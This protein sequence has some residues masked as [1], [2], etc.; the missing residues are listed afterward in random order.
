MLCVC[1]CVCVCVC[2]QLCPNLCDPMDGSL[3]GSSVHG[4]FQ[5]RILGSVAISYSR[6]TSWPRDGTLCLLCLL[7]C[8]WDSLPLCHLES[9]YIYSNIS[10]QFLTRVWL[11]ATPWIAAHQASLSITSSQ[12]LLKLMSIETEMPSNHLI[13]CHPLLLPPSIFPSIRVFSKSQFFTSG[14]QNI[15]VSPSTSVVPV[16]TQD[17]SPLEWTG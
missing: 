14:S 3:P 11:F 15:G 17:W 6:R 5:A 16:N 2:A 7:H 1:V 10:A 8:Q 13:F 9:L 12:N 4:I